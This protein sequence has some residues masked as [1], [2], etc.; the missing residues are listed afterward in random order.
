MLDYYEKENKKNEWIESN[1]IE[2]AKKSK[3][4]IDKFYHL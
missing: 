3:G 4:I 2:M 1:K